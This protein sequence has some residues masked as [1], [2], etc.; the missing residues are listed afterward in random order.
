MTLPAY[1]TKANENEQ[2]L[3]REGERDGVD[4]VLEMTTAEEEESLREDEMEALYQVRRARRQEA[5]ETRERRRLRREARQRGDMVALRHLS[6]QALASGQ[7][8]VLPGLREEATRIQ[9]RRQ[10]AVSS[11]SYAELGVARPDGTRLRANSQESERTGLLSDAASIAAF[12]ARSPSALSHRRERST[13]SV[14]SFDSNQDF[15]RSGATTPRRLSAQP[16]HN[17]ISAGSSPEI[18]GEAD[19]GDVEIPL[20]DPPR[21]DDVSLDDE[22]SR[23]GTP[24]PAINE[25]PPVYPGPTREWERRYSSQSVDMLEDVVINQPSSTVLS[26]N[27]SSSSSPRTTDNIPRLPS[28]RIGLPQ[29]VIEPSTTPGD[30][31][32]DDRQ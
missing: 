6:E 17:S 30:R 28:L 23:A 7:T 10:R 24:A 5:E 12:S 21:Y 26:R 9:G 29:I 15:P 8:S 25:P 18:I 3:G 1:R 32:H 22:R 27:S 31:S 13:S 19:L 2:V 20:H 4:V 16:S 11:V 14:L